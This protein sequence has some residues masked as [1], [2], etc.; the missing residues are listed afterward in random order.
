M[1]RRNLTDQ[2]QI[3]GTLA[4][5]QRAAVIAALD[6]CN[7]GITKAA[8]RL[9]IS[10]ATLYRYLDLLDIP[11]S[12]ANDRIVKLAA[13]IK[14][15]NSGAGGRIVLVNGRYQIEETVDHLDASNSM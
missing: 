4:H 15:R 9:G 10:R 13:A 3:E 6:H 12:P 11:K 1:A 7:Y 2:Y 8:S 5:A 14:N